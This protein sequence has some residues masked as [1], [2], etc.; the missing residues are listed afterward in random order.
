M[1]RP[2]LLDIVHGQQSWDVDVNLNTG[3][4]RD[5]SIP[6]PEYANLA[7]LP[8]AGSNDRCLVITTDQSKLWKSDGSRWLPVNGY[9]VSDAVKA[10]TV[11]GA[12]QTLKTY[13][14]AA[15]Y[16]VVGDRLILEAWGSFDDASEEGELFPTFEGTAF[17]PVGLALSGF[18][19]EPWRYRAEMS[20]TGAAT[21]E[22]GVG[23][24][25]AASLAGLTRIP[26]TAPLNATIDFDFTVDNID[27]SNNDAVTVRGFSIRIIPVA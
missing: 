26:T 6:V 19:G 13:Q 12:P 9:L 14:F 22:S 2:T 1:A 18:N 24:E 17:T 8:A 20:I 21:Q 5:Q 25:L 23:G 16:L 4:L 15:D 7:A 3:V 10:A 27:G 11:G